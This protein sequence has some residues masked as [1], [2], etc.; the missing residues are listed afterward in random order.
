M[1][2]Q[3]LWLIDELS[4]EKTHQKEGNHILVS[5]SVWSGPRTPFQAENLKETT[6]GS[7]HCVAWKHEPTK[8]YIGIRC[9]S[10]PTNVD[11][12]SYF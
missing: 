3:N 10:Q 12:F 5:G 1:W 9:D 8:I 2:F 11:G 6:K 7:E 4:H